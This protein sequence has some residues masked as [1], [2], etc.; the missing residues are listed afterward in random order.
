MNTSSS[1]CTT[2]CV[3]GGWLR[4]GG[5][6]HLSGLAGAGGLAALFNPLGEKVNMLEKKCLEKGVLRG[7]GADAGGY[8]TRGWRVGAG[9]RGWG[10]KRRK[11]LIQKEELSIFFYDG[12]GGQYSNL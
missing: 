3:C 10:Q 1:F 12:E 7:W 9:V 5:P 6:K 8:G 4:L 2:P 11:T